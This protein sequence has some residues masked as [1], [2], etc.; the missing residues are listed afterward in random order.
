MTTATGGAARPRWALVGVGLV[1]GFIA[2]LFGV[3]GGILV[4]PGL[5]L[6]GGLPQRVA[7][8]TSLAASAILASAGIVAYALNSA[9]DPLTA[10]LLFAGS[11][12]G[13]LGGVD[14]LNRVRMRT[15]Q[16][17]F[18]FL[19][20]VTAGRMLAGT[21]E[22]TGELSL[23][24]AMAFA[25]VATGVA[26]GL[27]AGLLGVGGGVIVV[28][29]LVLLFE[30][31]NVTAKGTSL[32]VVLP[33]AIVGT[34]RNVRYGNVDLRGA[35]VTGAGGVLSAFGGA[36]L[37]NVIPPQVASGLF[38]GLLMAIGLRML[39]GL[40]RTSG[41]GIDRLD[42]SAGPGDDPMTDEDDTGRID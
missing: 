23:T 14:L 6:F 33:T 1:A 20:G 27:V 39:H 2:G 34:L 37:A 25:L 32:L 7:H 8:G 18:V 22:S 12:L 40:V 42:A 4:A 30:M 15:L 11:S 28:P 19:L 21:S 36:L 29:A 38:A 5:M 13:V 26:V 16:A 41:R 24:V 3:G 17:A 10:L 35:L 31:A 9:V